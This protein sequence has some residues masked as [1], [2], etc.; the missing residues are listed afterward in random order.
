MSRQTSPSSP[1]TQSSA[2]SSP[3]SPSPST[4]GSSASDVDELDQRSRQLTRLLRKNLSKSERRRDVINK[5]RNKAW[6]LEDQVKLL[7]KQTEAA[8]QALAK[9]SVR[10][11]VLVYGAVL[12]T[13]VT[14]TRWMWHKP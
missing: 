13:V 9:N 6:L 12:I 7:G 11:K 1:D 2:W 4:N 8:R 14:V 5:V 3:R 10:G